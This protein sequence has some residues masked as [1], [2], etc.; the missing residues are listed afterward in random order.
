MPLSDETKDRYNAVLGI[1]K[2]VFSVGWI[3]LVIYIGYKNSSPQPSL[4]K[5]AYHPF[6]IVLGL[7][8]KKWRKN[9]CVEAFE[10]L[11]YLTTYAF[12][13]RIPSHACWLTHVTSFVVFD[14]FH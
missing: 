1:A 2:T 3:P 14:S 7:D 11:M 13:S 5:F 8:N 10:I 12:G 6:S 4:I 9:I